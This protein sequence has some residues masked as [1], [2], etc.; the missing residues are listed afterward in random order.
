MHNA[1][2]YQQANGPQRRDAELLINE[3]ANVLQWRPDGFDAILDIGCG[4]GDVSM[5]FLLPILPKNFSRFTGVDLS[6]EMVEYARKKYASSRIS[7]EQFNIGIDLEK[8]AIRDIEPFDHITSFYCLHW[9]KN[10]ARVAQNLYKL[11][12]PDGDILIVFLTQHPYFDIYR[13]VAR[14]DRWAEH[15]TDVE[16]FM[17]PFK[18]SND[19]AEELSG[20]LGEAGFREYQVELREYDYMFHGIDTLKSE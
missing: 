6:P 20:I 10:Q 8:Q 15:M 3:F 1:D 17:P 5:D 9:I 14:N 13:E 19:A 18:D 12:K 16:R 11:C 7:F 2:L 4:S